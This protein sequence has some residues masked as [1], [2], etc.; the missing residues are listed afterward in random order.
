MTASAAVR[1]AAEASAARPRPAAGGR[2]L[3][4]WPLLGLIWGYPVL[5]ALGLS[6]FAPTVLCLLMLALL[7]L[8]GH[9]RVLP[10]LWAWGALL[11][12]MLGSTAML[13]SATDLIGWGMRFTVVL[14]AGICA[15]YYANARETLGPD[16]VLRALS[17]LW[18]ACVL[19]GCLGLAFPEARLSTPM[20]AIMP[21]GLLSN[22]LVHD[23]VAPRLTE[24]QQ[25]WGAPAPYIRP[26][27]PFV[28]ANS[29]GLAYALLTPVVVAR[30]LRGA[31]LRVVL[32][33]AGLG[34]LSV[35]PALASS[36]R[37]MFL[38]L[39]LC[40]L[41][42]WI[43]AGLRGRWAAVAAGGLGLLA[44]GIALFAS[45]AAGSV[46][47]RQEYSDSTG[48]AQRPVPGHLGALPGISPPGPRHHP[49]GA[50]RRR[51]PGHPGLP[52]DTPVLLRVRRRGPVP[53]VPAGR[54]AA[55]GAARG[56]QRPLAARR[57]GLLLPD[58]RLLLLRH[59]A[60]DHPAAPHCPAGPR[61][62]G[63]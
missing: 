32:W 3:P 10:G 44:A 26:S 23:Y 28:Y 1:P 13:G 48:G 14:N 45:G 49:D 8:R 9:L 37:G 29:W 31:R 62:S 18:A 25:P 59:H 60:D 20:G 55:L 33:Y 41:T 36:N 16:A 11:L 58:V 61:P 39:G 6:Q 7:L 27:A 40:V 51:L 57:A 43:R 17:G 63:R 47:A 21:G 4:A 15:L 30:L 56:H 53:V 34:A 2:A 38:G 52:L 5:W 12:W 24:T 19:L 54:G 46:L 35:I 42:V 22:D 50:L